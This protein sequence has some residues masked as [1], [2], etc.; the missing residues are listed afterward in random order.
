MPVQLNIFLLLFGGLQGILLTLFLVR[1]KLYRSGYIFL[2]LYFAVLLLQIVLKVMSKAWLMD[3]WQSFYFLSYQLPFLY[4]PLIYLFAA[5]QTAKLSLKPVHLLHFIPFTIVLLL[6]TIGQS[7]Q[8][9][10]SLMLL[11]FEGE[12][13][14]ILQLISLCIYHLLAFR[15]WRKYSRSLKNDFSNIE[16]LQINWLQQFIFSSFA[17]CAIITVTIYLMYV[18]FPALN[19]L[20]IGFVSLTV[21]IYWVSYKALTQP[22]IFSLL[23]V[24]APE[25]AVV[26]PQQAIVTEIIPKLQVRRPAKKYSNSCLSEEEACRITAILPQLMASSRAYL[27]P[28]I[29]IDRLAQMISSNRHHLSQVLNE[30]LG[31][32]FYDY[33][34]SYRV[35]EARELLADPA[36][37][38]DKIATIAYD[39]GFNSLSAFNEVF[40]KWTG[41]TPSQYRNLPADIKKE[42]RG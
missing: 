34:N 13:R 35:D 32:S 18:F 17:V 3:N 31:L 16:R 5:Q 41:Q 15:C 26:K 30:K 29:T 27:E 39:A 25:E 12:R 19:W 37:S 21:F 24:P 23:P 2:L 40:K 10:D 7:F 28:D 33:V 20:R 22:D 1:K 36:K 8:F 4:G 42:K 6:L 9:S 11:F 14:L 38:G